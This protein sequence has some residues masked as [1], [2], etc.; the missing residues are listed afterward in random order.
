M[1]PDFCLL[2]FF[3]LFCLLSQRKKMLLQ[4]RLKDKKKNSPPYCHFP[5]I[6]NRD[7]AINT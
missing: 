3:A 2:C 7:L 4:K 6:S 1:Q 5:L